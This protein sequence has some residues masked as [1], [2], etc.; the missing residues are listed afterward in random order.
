V[1][2]IVYSYGNSYSSYFFRGIGIFLCKGIVFHRIDPNQTNF[3]SLF[4]EPIEALIP[5]PL[6]NERNSYS[7][8]NKIK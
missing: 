5:I 7:L 1:K 6:Q 8:K 3:R 4:H 2:N